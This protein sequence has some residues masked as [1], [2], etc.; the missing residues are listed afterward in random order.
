MKIIID[1]GDGKTS[2]FED[3]I[4]YGI[5]AKDDLV[6]AVNN[7]FEGEGID[8]GQGSKRTVDTMT[9]FHQWK[10]FMMRSSR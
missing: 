7:H 8:R 3:V 6:D 4:D 10:P 5:L 9:A 2:T 1:Y